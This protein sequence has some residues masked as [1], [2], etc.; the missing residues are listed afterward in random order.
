M[1]ELEERLVGLL[2][3]SA[4]EVLRIAPSEIEAPQNVFPD[5]DMN[6]VTGV[7]KL[8]DRL[9][10]LLDLGRILQRAAVRT[11][12]IR[13]TVRRPTGRRRRGPVRI[14]RPAPICRP[15]RFPWIGCTAMR[16]SFRW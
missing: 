14:C 15:G 9:I 3:N 7:G 12:D 4:S 16:K 11:P 2:V 1:V 13:T 6:Y 8:N 5:E 10:I